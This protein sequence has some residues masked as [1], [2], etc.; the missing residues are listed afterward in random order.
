VL[1][2]G[3]HPEPDDVA[4]ARRLLTHD[5]APVIVAG[6]LRDHLGARPE[7]VAAATAA[8]RAKLPP[9]QRVPASAAAEDADQLEDPAGRRSRRRLRAQSADDAAGPAEDETKPLARRSRRRTRPKPAR[10]EDQAADEPGEALPE[11]DEGADASSA[12]GSGPTTNPAMA[13]IFVNVGRT[14]GA[15]PDDFYDLLQERAQIGRD[16]PEYVRV[17]PRHTFVALPR[18]LLAKAIEALDG[19]TIAGRQATAE[20]ARPRQ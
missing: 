15:T 10:G 14:D 1:F 16:T 3:H 5:Q 13:E 7:M 11:A 18:E 6:L 4:L 2:T 8:R 19:A 17:R 20:P 12:V 9:P